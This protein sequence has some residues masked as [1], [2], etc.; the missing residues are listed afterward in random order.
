MGERTSPN[1]DVGAAEVRGRFTK[2]KEVAEY[3]NRPELGARGL[4]ARSAEFR[5]HG[6]HPPSHFSLDQH[7]T[8]VHYASL[9]RNSR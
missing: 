3:V 7:R 4:K 8:G 5:D 6:L 9:L 1:R 2:K